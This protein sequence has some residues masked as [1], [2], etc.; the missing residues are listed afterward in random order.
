MSQGVGAKRGEA[1]I[2]LLG[3]ALR[4]ASLKETPPSV[5]NARPRVELAQLAFPFLS[6]H[7]TC[8]WQPCAKW[9]QAGSSEPAVAAGHDREPKK[10]S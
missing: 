3:K 10:Q 1:D 2:G 7:H 6:S 8:A 4:F 9:L 5:E